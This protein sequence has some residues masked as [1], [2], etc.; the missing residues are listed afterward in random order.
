MNVQNAK[1]LT[2]EEGSVKTIHD[3]DSR[4]IWGA[5]GYDTKYAGDTYQ[6]T[7]SGKNKFDYES[8]SDT[9]N[10]TVSTYRLF[11]IKGL[12][13]NTEY[14]I[15][16]WSLTTSIPGTY[17]YLW[18]TTSYPGQPTNFIAS[19]DNLVTTPIQTTTQ[20][21]GKK[22]LAIYPSDATTWNNVIAY[23]EKCQF[24]EGNQATSYEPYVGGTASPNPDYPQDI[25]VVTGEQTVTVSDGD[26]SQSYTIDLGSIELCKIDT[27]KDKIFQNVPESDL[28]NPSLDEGD[29]YVHKATGKMVLNGS[30]V[31]ITWART[32]TGTPT[33]YCY[34]F[35]NISMG[36]KTA[37]H[38]KYCDYFTYSQDPY[39]DNV[40]STAPTPSL[41]ENDA[42]E[43]P[44]AFMFIFK[45]NGSQG[46]TIDDW[47]TWLSTH[48][49]T[50]YY[51]L[52]TPTDTKITDA[53]LIS[54]L[55]AIHQ[56]LTRYGYNSTVTG[57]LPL[58]ISQTDLNT[59]GENE[60][61]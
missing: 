37:K 14:T 46:T 4:L 40:T 42:I 44:S 29:W 58:I 7:Y 41:C 32:T 18:S 52:A 6:Q 22:Y 8:A 51:L 11:E 38:T 60:N 33:S 24:E 31:D 61:E 59:V 56:W 10:T 16:G 28:Y 9:D 13:P 17:I 39:N 5:V 12:K 19:P 2:I 27:Y 34:G 25:Q 3:K 55:N 21:D 45:T 53:T 1:N 43:T 36:A 15:S 57:N 50:V 23:F 47:K 49:T 26:T 48:N 20:A 54:Q 30:N 35:R